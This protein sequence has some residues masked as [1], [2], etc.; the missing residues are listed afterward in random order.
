MRTVTVSDRTLAREEAGTLTFRE[1]LELMKLIDR[2]GADYIEVGTPGAGRADA[3]CLKSMAQTAGAGITVSVGLDPAEADR[4]WDCLKYAKKPR[5]SVSCPVSVSQMEY[6]C[7]LKPVSAPEKIRAAVSHARTLCPDVEFVAADATRAEKDFL[8]QTVRAAIEAGASAVT[9]A[10]LTGEL[11]PDEVK[12]FCEGLLAAV[13]ELG[14]VTW[15][16]SFD[17][18][19]K[20]GTTGLVTAVACGA[21][22]IKAAAV[23]QGC[24]PLGDTVKI[25]TAKED[26]LQVKTNI[27]TVE[28]ERL[29]GQMTKLAGEQKSKFSPFDDGVSDGDERTFTAHDTRESISREVARLGYELSEEDDALVYE[30]FRAIAAK[31]DAVTGKEID[32]IVASV[33]MQVPPTYTIED[34]IINSGRNISATAHIRLNKQGQRLESVSLGDGSVDASFLAIE[35]ITGHHYELDD[36]Q[37]RAVTEGHEA[38]GET[39]V[40]LRAGNGKLYSGRGLSTDIVA[41]S[42]RAYVSALNKIA[43]EEDDR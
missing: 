5:L 13:P 8:A 34:F 4:A 1:K 38:M 25:L 3:L 21:G 33:A 9:F 26:V 11:L 15:G 30:A 32:A 18:G 22:E 24:V 41:S 10:D 40:K 29:L 17:D 35:Q 12:A 39:V 7:H 23:A 37:I 16:M 36:F 19:M 27:R 14:G 6:L 31:K 2:L 43:Y 20:L 42:I 28:A